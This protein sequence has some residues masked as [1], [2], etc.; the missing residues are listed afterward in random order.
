MTPEELTQKKAEIYDLAVAR[1]QAQAEFNK[2]SES[3]KAR[4]GALNNQI[5]AM[6]LEVRKAQKEASVVAPS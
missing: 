4:I 6:D 3:Q 2:I 5:G 1:D